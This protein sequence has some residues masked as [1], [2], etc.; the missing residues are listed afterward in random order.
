[1]RGAQLPNKQQL[2]QW[3]QQ[4]QHATHQQ[5]TQLVTSNHAHPLLQDNYLIWFLLQHNCQHYETMQMALQ[6]RAQQQSSTP[7][8]VQQPL[9]TSTVKQKT[10][11]IPTQ[12]MTLG[13]HKPQAYDNELPAQ[14][15]TI[16]AFRISEYPTSNTQYLAFIEAGGYQTQNL[17]S[18][19]GWQWLKEHQAKAPDHWRQDSQ[20]NWYAIGPQGP[21][22][23]PANAPVYGINYYEASAYVCWAGGRLPHEHE[24]ETAFQ[25]QKL[26][27]TG[28]AW[29][30]CQ[31]TL[32]PYS[33]FKSF[34]Y[35]SYSTPWF[36]GN[37]YMLKGGSCYTQSTL[38]RPS[39][40]NFY[41]PDKR[42]I[43]AGLRLANDE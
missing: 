10:C 8:K 27:K 17:W 28:H 2:L 7:Y 30:W 5:L 22:D 4:T 23:L 43:F 32:H 12:K 25:A 29:E 31:N 21:Y 16:N 38:K 41:Q 20:H 33:N 19:E 40:R 14:T 36:D 42:H 34:P 3:C 1:M 9:K 26:Q 35:T 18:E 39:F 6:Q 11:I 13:G 37:H 15:I 24:W